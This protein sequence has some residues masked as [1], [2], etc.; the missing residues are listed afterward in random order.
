MGGADKFV[1]SPTL[2]M[3]NDMVIFNAVE[4]SWTIMSPINALAKRASYTATLLPNGVIVYIGGYEVA[5]EKNVFQEVEIKQINLYDTHSSNWTKKV[6]I[7]I[8]SI[9]HK[10]HFDL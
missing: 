4:S 2:K 9:C 6:C 5:G 3:F 7:N 8:V 1:G 10:F